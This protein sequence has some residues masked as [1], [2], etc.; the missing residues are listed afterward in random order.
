[1]VDYSKGKIYKIWDNSYTMCYVGSTTQPLSK[2]MVKHRC[3]YKR[4]LQKKRRDPISVFKIF[5]EF[6]I[7]NCKIELVEDFPCESKE[8]LKAREGQRQ[9]ECECVNKL[10]AGRSQKECYEDKKDERLKHMKEYRDKNKD[11]PLFKEMKQQSQHIYY[12]K[13]EKNY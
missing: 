2:R 4:Y 8:E 13:T 6:G 5:K 7:E 9:K 1:M 3:D 10:I 12:E 11:N